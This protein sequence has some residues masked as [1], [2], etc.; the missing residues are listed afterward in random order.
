VQTGLELMKE[1]SITSPSRIVL[2]V[3]DGLGGLPREA[4]GLTELETALT[5]NMD[6]LASSGNCGLLQTVSA[7][8]T[9]GSAPGHLGLFGYNPLEYTIGRGVLEALGMDF[10]LKPGDIAARGNFCT[11]D[12]A[13]LISDRRAGRISTEDG[14]KLCALLDGME[15]EGVKVLVQAVKEHRLVAVFRGENLHEGLSDADPQQTGMPPKAVVALNPAAERSAAIVNKFLSEARKRLAPNHPANMVLLRGF[16]GRPDFPSMMDIYKLKAAAIASYPMY[17]GLAKVVG[18]DVL[19]TG[20]TLADELSTLEENFQR[21]DFFFLHV[22]GADAAGEDG[23]FARKVSVIEEVDRHLPRLL[24][25]N[26]EV[27]V[28]TGD[29]STPA[30]MSG[31]SWHP[32]PCLLQSRFCRPDKLG[33]FGES[34]CR[35]GSL[36]LIPATS[37]MPQAM[38]HGLKLTKFGA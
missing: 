17:R 6:K 15:I 23:D 19:K 36:G 32:V 2:L 5:P 37:L 3:V 9:P 14:K 8:I 33:K 18:M 28:I 35:L 38:A 1:L 10:D 7:G 30:A 13:G 26:P 24:A 31:H 27:L 34:F 25:L 22:K 20:P 4:G 21:Y 12:A 29:H 16:S 11:L